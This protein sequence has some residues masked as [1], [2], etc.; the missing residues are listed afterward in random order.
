MR[1]IFSPGA[2][3][4]AFAANLV[5]NITRRKLK[6]DRI[7]PIHGTVAPFADLLKT[8]APK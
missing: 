6:I 3:V 2:A 8:A 1:R 4:N 7:V 5:D